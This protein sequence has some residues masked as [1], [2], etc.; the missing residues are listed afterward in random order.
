MPAYDYR[1]D[2]CNCNYEETQRPN[3]PHIKV[4]PS[5]G[6]PARRVYSLAGFSFTFKYGWD[7][8]AGQG[9][10]SKKQRDEHLARNGLRK[11]S[12]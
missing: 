6:K 4:C 12:V 5:C 10:D 2:D 8:G 7:A 9:F 11:R 3:D 1:C